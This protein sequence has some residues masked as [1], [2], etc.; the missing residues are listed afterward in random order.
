MTLVSLRSVDLV[1]ESW[2]TSVAPEGS[3]DSQVPKDPDVGTKPTDVDTSHPTNSTDEVPHSPT[4]DVGVKPTDVILGPLRT[5]MNIPHLEGEKGPKTVEVPRTSG[6]KWR[7][8]VD[9]TTVVGDVYW[10]TT[11]VIVLLIETYLIKSLS[12]SVYQLIL[13]QMPTSITLVLSSPVSF[14]PCKESNTKQ[15]LGY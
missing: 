7:D 4:P 12:L 5:G 3:G 2:D 13:L 10:T 11:V 8:D 1:C 15:Y 6:P 14:H 9:R